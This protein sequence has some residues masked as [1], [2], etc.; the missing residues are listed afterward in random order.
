M[1]GG[2]G[3]GGG[4]VQDIQEF[5]WGFRVRVVLLNLAVEM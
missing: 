4:G 3:G 5:S 2:E 1:K